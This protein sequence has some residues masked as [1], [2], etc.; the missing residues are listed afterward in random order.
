MEPVPNMQNRNLDGHTPWMIVF[1]DL[2]SLL[3]AFFVLL[4]SMAEI[5]K[6]NI[7]R[8]LESFQMNSL[9]R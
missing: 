6:G 1:A 8:F 3:L 2:L 7:D 9:L 5:P 4:F